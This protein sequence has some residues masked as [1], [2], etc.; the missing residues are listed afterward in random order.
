MQLREQHLVAYLQLGLQE[1]Q[2]R[3]L[4]LLP[5]PP[6]LLPPTQVQQVAALQH[7]LPLRQ[8]LLQVLEE[9]FLRTQ[10]RRFS[11]PLPRRR[12]QPLQVELLSESFPPKTLD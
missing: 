11:V 3:L 12:L 8:H 2:P 9:A 7:L 4:L 5:L 10:G 6:Q 1:P